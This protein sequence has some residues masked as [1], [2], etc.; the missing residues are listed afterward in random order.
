[1]IELL[2]SGRF[3]ALL[4]VL[5][6]VVAASG[7]NVGDTTTSMAQEFGTATVVPTTVLE[8]T[9]GATTFVATTRVPPPPSDPEVRLPYDFPAIELPGSEFDSITF[10]SVGEIPLFENVEVV[11]A[12]VGEGTAAWFLRFIGEVPDG[13]ETDI[14]RGGVQISGLDLVI[15]G[16]PHVPYFENVV[17]LPLDSGNVVVLT[18]PGV[19]SGD[20]LLLGL[21]N[22]DEAASTYDYHPFQVTADDDFLNASF[23]DEFFLEIEEFIEGLGDDR[24]DGVAVVWVEDLGIFAYYPE[25]G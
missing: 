24:E 7:D 20:T 12:P 4:V 22:V 11:A 13:I 21:F 9:T 3:V 2:R 18:V 23:D 16:R 8:A 17:E 19:E 5:M 1:M 25:G 14:L 6:V 10:A 15:G